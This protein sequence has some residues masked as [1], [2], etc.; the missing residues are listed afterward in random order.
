M[1]VTYRKAGIKDID[2]VT[3]LLC[4]LYQMPREELLLENERHINDANMIF[5]IAFDEDNAVGVAH[6]SLR[7]EYVNGANDGV[8]GYLEGI[9]VLP[10]YRLKGIGA[11]LV[12]FVEDWSRRYGCNEFASDCLVDNIDS[13]NFHISI[14]FRE[15]ERNIFF[16]K[17]IEPYEYIIYKIDS[18]LRERIQPIIIDTW[19]SRYL[20][21][22]GRLWDSG[23]MPG[24]AAVAGDTVLGYL[25]YEFH[26]GVCEIM[27]LESLAQNIGVASA[28]IEQVK[29]TAK[30][31]GVRKLIVQTSNDNSRAFRFYQRRGFRIREIRINALDTAR[32]LKPSIPPNGEDEIPLRDEIEFEIDV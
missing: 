28:L 14:G 9:Y 27:A 19:G 31:N 13:Y 30:S 10:E 26:N 1:T 23:V 16:L 29:L 12:R 17:A 21:V 7:R 5:Y 15:S 3:D 6:G 4:L 8:K 11:K 24:Y 2:I 32:K 18:D 22:N 25:I 20:A